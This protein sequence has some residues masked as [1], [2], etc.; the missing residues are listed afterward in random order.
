MDFRI[1]LYFWSRDHLTPLPFYSTPPSWVLPVFPYIDLNMAIYG[2][3]VVASVFGIKPPLWIYSRIPS[4]KLLSPSPN[5]GGKGYK[6]LI[7]EIYGY[8]VE[9]I[10]LGILTWFLAW[11]LF[12]GHIL[13]LQTTTTLLCGSLYIIKCPPSPSWVLPLL[14]YIDLNMAI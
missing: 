12:L 8:D 14:P 3:Q 11:I 5:G 9:T 7:I 2:L 6:H 1:G 13:K 4:W 10:L